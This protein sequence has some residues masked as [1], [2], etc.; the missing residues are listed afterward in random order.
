[1]AK[2]YYKNKKLIII[3]WQKETQN[4]MTED[5]LQI[6]ASKSIQFTSGLPHFLPTSNQPYG[7][8]EVSFSIKI[9]SHF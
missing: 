4:L 5:I 9:N 6:V 7:I 3:W 2:S 8:L 1:M